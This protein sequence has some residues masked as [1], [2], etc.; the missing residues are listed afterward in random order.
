MGSKRPVHR[1]DIFGIK[2][3]LI[4]VLVSISNVTAVLLLPAL[5][6]RRNY[7]FG[8]ESINFWRDKIVEIINRCI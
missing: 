1:L 2:D 4:I 5:D 3:R 8:K 7:L 6:K